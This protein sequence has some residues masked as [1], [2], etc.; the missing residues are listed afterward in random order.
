[1]LDRFEMNN[2]YVC[3]YRVG[4][5]GPAGRVLI[6][7]PFGVPASV[8]GIVADELAGE[9]F[10][11]ITLDVRN[12]VGRGSGRMIDFSLPTVVDDCREAIRRYEPT[13]VVGL[14][15]GA[16]AALRAMATSPASPTA[17]LM[18]PVVEMRATLK[19]VLGYDPLFHH[20]VPEVEEV[21]GHRIRSAPFV[22]GALMHDL[23][24][25]EGTIRDLVDH[26]GRITLIPADADPWVDLSSVA[27]VADAARLDGASID[28]V[29]VPGDEHELHKHPELALRMISAAVGEVV[30]E[31]RLAT[32]A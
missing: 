1:M 28:V 10:E 15:L 9:G 16:R 3:A 29:P 2:G 17:V 21:L 32:V 6:V 31:H 27:L 23:F 14:S 26:G 30:R 24:S 5:G 18:I 12:H 22:D 7:P 4:V 19:T 25:I 20:D 13:A 8:L 11:A